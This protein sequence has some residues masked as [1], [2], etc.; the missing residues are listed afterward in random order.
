MQSEDGA[1]SMAGGQN[2]NPNQMWAGIVLTAL[3]TG[4]VTAG[5]LKASFLLAHPWGSAGVLVLVIVLAAVV[6]IVTGVWNKVRDLLVGWIVTRLKG[7]NGRFERAYLETVRA[8]VRYFENKGLPYVGMGDL[9]MDAVFV[10]PGVVPRRGRDRQGVLPDVA[11]EGSERGTLDQML[12]SENNDNRVLVVIGAPG[13]GKTTL[14]RHVAARACEEF[15]PRLRPRVRPV[16]IPV[17]LYLRDHASTI[18]GDPTVDVPT[19]VANGGGWP[20]SPKEPSGWLAS[21]LQAGECIVLL[22]GL[23]EVAKPEDRVVVADWVNAQT[24]ASPKCRFVISSRPGG[25]KNNSVYGAKEVRVCGFTSVQVRQF[26]RR[27]YGPKPGGGRHAVSVSGS[28][29]ADGLWRLLQEKPATYDLT[30]N[31]LLL[32][33]IAAVHM[34]SGTLPA[35]RASLYYEICRVVLWSRAE[36]KGQVFALT[37]EQRMTILAEVAY[38]MMAR[39]RTGLSTGEVEKII[40]PALSRRPGIKSEKKAVFATDLLERENSDGLLVEREVGQYSFAH[41]TFQEYLAAVHIRDTPKKNL[42]ANLVNTVGDQWWTETSIFYAAIAGTDPGA[43]PIVDACLNAGTSTALALALECADE[44]QV[45]DEGLR[46]KVESLL[47]AATKLGSDSREGF[48]GIRVLAG[49]LLTRHLRERVNLSNGTQVCIR[50]IPARIYRLFLASGAT[51]APDAP[52]GSLAVSNNPAVGMRASEAAEFARW[53]NEITDRQVTY[54]FLRPEEHGEL[55]AQQ[56]IPVLPLALS[57]AVWIRESYQAVPHLSAVATSSG[58][59]SGPFNLIAQT[60]DELSRFEY[61]PLLRLAYGRVWVNFFLGKLEDIRL[62]VRARNRVSVLDRDLDRVRVAGLARVLDSVLDLARDRDLIRVY[63]RDLG[64][65]LDLALDRVRDLD[66]DLDR[67]RNRVFTLDLD[68]ALSH[69][70]ARDLA[71]VFDL[72]RDLARV[73]ARDLDRVRSRRLTGA[74]GWI[75]VVRDMD[76]RWNAMKFDM[77]TIGWCAWMALGSSL[78]AG[79]TPAME[80]WKALMMESRKKKFDSNLEADMRLFAN[81]FLKRSGVFSEWLLH[82]A[83]SPGRV[84][85]SSPVEAL[86]EALRN[87]GDGEIP[88]GW[89]E[90]AG[91]RLIENAQPIFERRERATPEKAAAIRLTALCLAG[92]ALQTLNDPDLAKQFRDIVEEITWLEMRQSGEIPATEVIMLAVE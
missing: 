14:L 17:L 63:G 21:K 29:E 11:A 48:E 33:M 60:V 61:F 18:I 89:A 50:V 15:R 38:E 27:W 55:S 31:P 85:L 77:E 79:L 8:R 44:A 5:A 35:N 66:R 13:S 9:A 43:D 12:D 4:T 32:T 45:L 19:L 36:A 26:L 62:S 46:S 56:R 7:E 70:L 59:M 58:S 20:A 73:L 80:D 28:D 42:V 67:V 51:P 88:V 57:P 68:R 92:E 64:R 81:S 24:S 82:E 47:E 10:D 91:A 2:Q 72:A 22:D 84:T 6:S 65:D 76:F 54:S 69:D 30:V 1:Q 87:C 25:Y 75:P 71:R 90:N 83:Y 49:A 40:G 78:A 52:E 39:E 23:D 34:E 86:V 16:R 37:G 53:A 74:W 41:K 3:L